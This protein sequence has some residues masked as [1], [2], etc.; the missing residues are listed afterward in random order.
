MLAKD[1]MNPGVIT[2]GPD[3]SVTDIAALLMDKNISAVPVIG[4]DKKLCGI[5]S[6]GDLMR[7]I[8]SDGD[9]KRSWWLKMVSSNS[10]EA[11]DFL[12]AHGRTA[13]DVMTKN[14]ETVSEDTEIS[15]VAQILESHHIKRVP[16]TDDGKVVGI[17]SRSNLLQL[18]A[19]QKTELKDQVSINDRD[20]RRQVYDSLSDKNFASH[21]TLNVIVVNGV[22]E[23]WGW[24]ETETE[25]NA[26]LLAA[27]EVPGVHEVKDHFGKVS[28]W[29]WGA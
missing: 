12:K 28:P 22:V 7:R 13:K 24:V 8:S 18:V 10:E 17:I 2:V 15:E 25:R 16:V 6:E 19:G 3:T 5:V 14:V 26:L 29:V 23:L 9:D 27:S 11:Y 1:L 4:D 20:L 21:G